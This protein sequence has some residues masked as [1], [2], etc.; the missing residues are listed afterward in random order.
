LYSIIGVNLSNICHRKLEENWKVIRDEGVAALKSV[1][2]FQDE[3]ENLRDVGD[4]K[5]FELY[6]R[7]K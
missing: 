1:G 6:A 5:Q 7:G 4:W 3:A 2:A